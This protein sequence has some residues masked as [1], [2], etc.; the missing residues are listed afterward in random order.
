MA[1]VTQRDEVYAAIEH[2]EK[3][4]GDFDVLINNAG[5]AQVQPLSDVT[6]DV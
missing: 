1:E 2:A 3:A 4:L 6:P 5:I